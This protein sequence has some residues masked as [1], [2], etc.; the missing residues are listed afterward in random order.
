M[1]NDPSIINADDQKLVT[2]ILSAKNRVVFVA[3]GV[4]EAVSQVLVEKW[5]ELGPHA[6]QVILD[7]D[8][9]VS[10]LGYGTLDGLKIIRD[11]AERLQTM[12]CH[13]PGIRIGLL[14][15]D[16][17][18]LVYSPTPLLVEA[19]SSQPERPNAIQ[20]TAPPPELLRD[21]GLGQRGG[22]DRVIGL[23][24]VESST[25]QR[26]E[27]NLKANPPVKFDLARKVRV[28]TSRF[29]FVELEM[30][31]IYISRKRVPIP[32]S[33]IGLTRNREVQSQFHAHFNLVNQEKLEVKVDDKRIL[34]EKSLHNA[35]Q[36]IIRRFL[37]PLKGYGMVVLR[38]NK[39]ALIE[40]VEEL[41][42]DVAAFQSGVKDSLQ[43][44]MDANIAALVDGLFPAVKQNPPDQYTKYHGRNIPEE[45]LKRM[46]DNDIRR[47]FGEANLLV[48]DMRI[49][50][51]FKDLTYESL[52]DESFLELARKAIPGLDSLHD[53]FVAAK[54]HQEDLTAN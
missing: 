31:G 34:T 7:V 42:V 8:P 17:T 6:V 46:L 1:S 39:E 12:I 35:R 40:A 20:L 44:C 47:A 15:A 53:E 52:K 5:T 43:K 21:I 14:I 22:G 48:Q 16:E 11:C 41:R 32:S 49:S 51:V 30:T 10:R 18:T 4:S 19:G 29:Q 50:L 36:E 27:A 33:L 37:I 38:V 26:V 2:Y 13:H 28:F 9:E 3:P 24:G 54:A 25:I 23:E 45:D